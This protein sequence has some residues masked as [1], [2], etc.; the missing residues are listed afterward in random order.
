[1]RK[2][3]VFLNLLFC[4]LASAHIFCTSALQAEPERR[5]ES[6]GSVLSGQA[7]ICDEIFSALSARLSAEERND[8]ASVS[9]AVRSDRS[10][11]KSYN[12]VSFVLLV[13]TVSVLITVL[14]LF[15]AFFIRNSIGTKSSE[16][17]VCESAAE[18]ALVQRRNGSL[19]YEIIVFSYFLI[20]LT[21]VFISV[22]FY[23]Y[24]IKQTERTLS[25]GLVSRVNGFLSDMSRGVCIYLADGSDDELRLISGQTDDV[26]EA[27]GAA[28]VVFSAGDAGA[29]SKS[30]ILM[31]TDSGIRKEPDAPGDAP[32]TLFD[33]ENSA[34][35][36][37]TIL[38]RMNEIAAEK[39]APS[40]GRL[41]ALYEE[42]E[43]RGEL[44]VSGERLIPSRS[45]EPP[46]GDILSASIDLRRCCGLFA[47]GMTVSAP[48]FDAQNYNQRQNSYLFCRP[49]IDVGADS[50]EF[51]R[52]LVF[53]QV[54]TDS[55][56]AAITESDRKLFLLVFVVVGIMLALGC[57][58][59]VLVGCH[60]SAPL[61]RIEEC[62]RRMT[63]EQKYGDA[64]GER[65]NLAVLRTDEIGR[66]CSAVNRL[67]ESLSDA[68]LSNNPTY[69]GKA[70]QKAF[71]PLD[72]TGFGQEMTASHADENIELF[73]FYN[74]ASSVSGDYFDYKRLD[75]RW[76][77][78]IK[79][80]VSGHGTPAALIM[81][82]IAVLFNQFFDGWSVD[83][84]GAGITKFVYQVNS[85]LDSLG[86]SGKF[87]TIIII[88][89]DS[90]SGCMYLCNAGDNLVHMYDAPSASLK[91]V[92]LK[93]TP[94]AGAFSSALIDSKGGF[95]LEKSMLAHGNILFLYTD[96]IV[97]SARLVRD[98]FGNAVQEERNGRYEAKKEVFGE[99][100]VR[101]VI[102]AVFLRGTFTLTK[103]GEHD[104]SESLVFDFSTCQG[105][106]DEAITA[107]A[108]VEKV[109]RMYKPLSSSESD[110]VKADRQTDLFLMEHF[111]LYKKYCSID[112]SVSPREIGKGFVY[113]NF[114]KEDEQSDDLTL[115]A[116]KR[117]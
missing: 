40:R 95:V 105:S 100:R 4:F 18:T 96:G 115:F 33:S 103:E 61:C 116:V 112:T 58:A 65:K 57:I 44:P 55:L 117:R 41:R 17:A 24:Y 22:P 13:L 26:P 3:V 85:F 75:E 67:N 97:E 52:G 19:L 36:R 110:V 23:Q 91:T 49:V 78:F 29:Y 15:S 69:D 90:E 6:A 88:L 93:E 108:A 70:V 60:I 54:S 66:L 56:T 31:T 1:M 38:R 72:K 28:A 102:E 48:E 8:I 25:E 2:S 101:T 113:Y 51:V 82:I 34:D 92:V 7:G 77:V 109:F 11:F 76:Y 21:A 53:V 111:N 99:R 71:L 68:A 73:G 35:V 94:A 47:D 79:S 16:K 14:V 12:K 107:L 81:T 83:K 59:A 80:D 87:A 9:S 46:D 106:I 89:F 39:T 10:R 30:H 27:E 45:T 84:D 74:G 42:R 32:E 98:G 86:L 5:S 62:I 37:R 114:V 104:N 50:G 43:Q 64:G 20:L 63:A